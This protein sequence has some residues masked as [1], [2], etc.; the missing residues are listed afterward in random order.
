MK[1]SGHACISITFG[2]KTKEIGDRIK[3]LIFM[4][5]FSIFFAHP[6]QC[7]STNNTHGDGGLGF[8]FSSTGFSP[9]FSSAVFSSGL[10]SSF[11]GSYTLEKK[12][13]KNY[14]TN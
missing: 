1:M 14:K 2:I 12:Q 10:D 8:F 9:F 6:T 5:H 13:N 4:I 3:P 7:K 11:A